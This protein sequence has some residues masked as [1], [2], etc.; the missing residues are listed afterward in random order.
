VNNP[1]L[2][3]LDEL[4]QGLDPQARHATW[5]LIR[6]IRE[7]GKTVVLVTHFMDEAEALCDRVTIIDRGR[8]VAM[9][10]PQGLVNGLD[11]PTTI[12]FSTERELPDLSRITGVRQV[13]RVGD[14]VQVQG[15]GAVL[16]LVAAELVSR[17]IVPV[18]LRA[19]RPTLEDA[20]LALT[21]RSIR[22]AG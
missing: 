7:R 2:V 10:T 18:D 3:F 16:A 15:T 14:E 20:F 13:T 9:D 12:R 11:V 8:L 5:T 21:G 1:K 6:D 22:D 17:G 4:T 19:E